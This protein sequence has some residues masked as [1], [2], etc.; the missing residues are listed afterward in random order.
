MVGRASV[1][2]WAQPNPLLHQKFISSRNDGLRNPS[3]PP[4]MYK[5]PVTRTC[6]LFSWAAI[7]LARFTALSIVGAIVTVA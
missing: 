1:N 3:A 2:P 7:A 4:T 5:L 6:M